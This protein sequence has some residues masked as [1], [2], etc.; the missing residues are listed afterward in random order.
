MSLFFKKI[1]LLCAILLLIIAYPL[2]LL[3]KAGEFIDPDTIVARQLKERN[4]FHQAYTDES[5]YIKLQNVRIREPEVLVLG[6]SRVMGFRSFF[7]RNPDAF[8][9]ASRGAQ[10]AK[11]LNNFLDSI[12]HAYPKVLIVSLDQ[13]W[14]NEKSK[15]SAFPMS[16]DN[17]YAITSTV[18]SSFK[19]VCFDILRGKASFGKI[20]APNKD[21]GLFAIMRNEGFRYDGSFKYNKPPAPGEDSLYKFKE[22]YESIANGTNHYEHGSIVNPAEVKE[23]ET[24]LTKCQ[25]KNIHV[26][27]FLPPYTPD[28][29]Q[30]LLQHK[31]QYQYLFKLRAMLP[32]VFSKYPH[33]FADFSDIAKIGGTN[34]EAFDGLHVSE[35]TNLRMMIE[36]CNKDTVLNKY[37]DVAQLQKLLKNADNPRDI[38]K[39]GL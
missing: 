10:S 36:M 11:G 16:L 32:A 24:F 13:F 27:A 35:N 30:K 20:N 31:A 39:G 9:N 12:P 2:Y 7:F 15:D 19:R 29:W 25:Q 8:Y 17:N 14:F 6:S 37:C 5:G 21:M 4:T 34:M 3:I 38:L 26:V 33:S 28:V 23:L 18:F 22:T 1:L